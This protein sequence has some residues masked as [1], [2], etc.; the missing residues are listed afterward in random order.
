VAG[1]GALNASDAEPWEA[2]PP[3]TDAAAPGDDVDPAPTDDVTDDAAGFT[4]KSVPVVTV[5]SAPS[6]VGPSARITAP[7]N[8][9]ATR[10]AAASF[11]ALE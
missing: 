2:D 9:R 11:D 7:E 4:E 1:V 3:E 8:E 5:T 10:S 6:V